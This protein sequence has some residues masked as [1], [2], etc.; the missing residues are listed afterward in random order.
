MKKI[1]LSILFAAC[2]LLAYGQADSVSLGYGI[3]VSKSESTV[4]A[5]A[6]TQA[7][8]L[9]T[10]S[11][12]SLNSLYGLIPGLQVS[13]G[14]SL[15]WEDTPGLKI[16][17]NGSFSGNSVLV[18][19]DGIERDAALISPNEIETITVLRDAAATALYGNRAADGVVVITTKRGLSHKT[20][21]KANYT[22]GTVTPF[23]IPKM[24]GAYDYALAVNEA[25]SNDGLEPKFSQN[26][27]KAIS[28]GNADYLPDNGWKDMVLKSNGFTNDLNIS[29]DG[30]NDAL[31]YFVYVDF[32]SYSGIFKDTEINDGYSTQAK[33]TALKARANIDSRLTKT[34]FVRFNLMGRLDQYQQPNGGCGLSSMYNTPP[35]PSPCSTTT[36]MCAPASS[37]ILTRTRSESD[38]PPL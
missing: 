10:D 36:I 13:Q 32:D 20:A 16:R 1:V 2:S 35:C 12:N 25:L 6:V 37:A 19:V 15:P 29:F 21:V 23:R 33:S 4:S 38:T 3:S 8:L 5:D 30:A 34:T 22:F 17:G 11:N 31:K 28:D 27:L 18:I 24:V 7:Q 14:G 9:Y 26:D